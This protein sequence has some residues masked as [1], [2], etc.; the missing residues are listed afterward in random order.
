MVAEYITE[1]KP[2]LVKHIEVTP[3]EAM[4]HNAQFV[5]FK[6]AEDEK[7]FFNNHSFRLEVS[8]DGE[9]MLALAG[10]IKAGRAVYINATERGLNPKIPVLETAVQV[11]KQL[12]K[13]RNKLQCR[14]EKA[15]NNPL[16]PSVLSVF[17]AK[18]FES[19]QQKS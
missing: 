9:L 17:A 16:Q 5:V 4:A 8:R 14:D 18:A 10:E 1:E 11:K 6:T 15:E 13:V 7:N 2:E 19:Q 12:D 3:R